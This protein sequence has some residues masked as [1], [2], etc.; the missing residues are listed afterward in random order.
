LATLLLYFIKFNLSKSRLLLR[1][2]TID[3]WKCDDEPEIAP[4]TDILRSNL[5]Q[6]LNLS[7]LNI[8][9]IRHFFGEGG[10]L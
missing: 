9:K 4:F 3:L 10:D 7:K 1:D 5:I 6:T 8:L 2:F